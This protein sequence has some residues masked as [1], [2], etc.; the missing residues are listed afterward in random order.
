M[1]VSLSR[2][3]QYYLLQGIAS[4]LCTA[5]SPLLVKVM[6]TWET[7]GEFALKIVSIL[8]GVWVHGVSQVTE[9]LGFDCAVREPKIYK[10]S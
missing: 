10:L 6:G 1:L 9:D 2:H 4:N 5:H 3:A 7:R 8:E